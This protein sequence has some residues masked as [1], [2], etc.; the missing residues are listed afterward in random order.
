MASTSPWSATVLIVLWVCG[1]GYS[2][3]S[4]GLIGDGS[5][6]LL[7]AVTVGPYKDVGHER[8]VPNLLAQLP[9]AAALAAG[10]TDLHWLA[11][12]QSLGW[13]ALP[14]ILYSLAVLRTRRD[15]LHQASVVIAI[16]GGGAGSGGS[17]PASRSATVRERAI[18]SK[19]RLP[20]QASASGRAAEVAVISVV[21]PRSRA[22]S[23]TAR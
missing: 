17:I 20:S 10:V 1:V 16:P 2:W 9:L 8:A 19:P 21:L 4:C 13:F 14:A 11:R 6:Y 22:R 5:Y 12:L 18:S 3:L 7:D 23:E 15:P